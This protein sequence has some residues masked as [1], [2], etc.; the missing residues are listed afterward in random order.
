MKRKN[1]RNKSL[2]IAAT[3][4]TIG[5]TG[6]SS[7]PA[8]AAETPAINS[9]TKESYYSGTIDLM[10]INEFNKNCLSINNNNSRTIIKDLK[11]ARE[12]TESIDSF[13]VDN[14]NSN[15]TRIFKSQQKTY[16]NTDTVTVTHAKEFSF[17]Q[18][19]S[20]ELGAP[21]ILENLLNMAK[22]NFKATFGQKITDSKAE[23]KSKEQ[24]T[25][26]G[27]DNIEV[28]PGQKV[29][30]EYEYITNIYSGTLETLTP[31][32]YNVKDPSMSYVS[33][34][35]IP[36]YKKTLPYVAKLSGGK[37]YSTDYEFFKDVHNT[38]DD[39]AVLIAYDKGDAYFF[40]AWELKD[41]TTL[42]DNKKQVYSKGSSK[43]EAVRGT[44]VKVKVTDLDT[45]KIVKDKVV[46]YF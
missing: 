23:A 7:T 24:S 35:D 14:S 44:G 15:S 21:K 28:K 8:F 37:K 3:I 25:T 4:S 10:F 19:I 38:P 29:K 27:G 46:S 30:V 11:P 2:L 34:K 41:T 12:Q 22:I 36:Y 9:K 33:P 5:L 40:Y 18:E 6:I 20:A 39:W 32:K 45:G 17:G 26:Y 43:F 16:K 31:L 42:N 1:N 13:E